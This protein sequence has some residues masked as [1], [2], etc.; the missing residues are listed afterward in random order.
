MGTLIKKL[1]DEFVVVP[2]TPFV[3]LTFSIGFPLIESV[4]VPEI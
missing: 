3:M 1:P 4:T 2:I